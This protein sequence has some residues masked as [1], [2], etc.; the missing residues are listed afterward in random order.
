MRKPDYNSQVWILEKLAMKAIK[1]CCILKIYQYSKFDLTSS[2]TKSILAWQI[3][4]NKSL[5]AK[6]II[7]IWKQ[8]KVNKIK[9]WKR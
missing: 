1:Q 9:A 4:F 7:K 2:Y 8:D 6:Y 3:F 5:S